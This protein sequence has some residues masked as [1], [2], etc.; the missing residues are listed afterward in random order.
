MQKTLETLRRYLQVWDP[1]NVIDDL[2]RDGL[3]PDEYD[4]YAGPLYTLLSQDATVEQIEEYLIQVLGHMG[5]KHSPE[6]DHD[7]ALSIH[8]YFYNTSGFKK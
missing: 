5:L 8:K 6:R 2:V 4:S 7:M 1:I 3:A